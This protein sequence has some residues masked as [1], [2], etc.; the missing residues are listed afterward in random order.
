[1]EVGL[2]LGLDEHVP[3]IDTLLRPKRLWGKVAKF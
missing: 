2:K 1:M 3:T